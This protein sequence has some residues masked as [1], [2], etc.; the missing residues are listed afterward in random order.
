MIAVISKLKLF[1]NFSLPTHKYA[2]ST[3]SLWTI[4]QSN[5]HSNY[6]FLILKNTRF[7]NR[8]YMWIITSLKSNIG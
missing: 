7:H 1:I 5:P 6:L 4:S 8:F 3:F 2:N